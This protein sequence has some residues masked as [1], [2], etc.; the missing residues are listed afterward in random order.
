MFFALIAKLLQLLNFLTLSNDQ[1]PV[2]P[3]HRPFEQSLFLFFLAPACE[4]GFEPTF[5]T[6]AE[7]NIQ[8]LNLSRT[9]LQGSN[10]NRVKASRMTVSAD[11]LCR[12]FFWNYPFPS[13]K[14]EY[15]DNDLK[16]CAFCL[17]FKFPKFS[18]NF[19]LL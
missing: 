6:Q 2:K 5:L 3:R 1:N 19:K 18:L 13:K 10:S 8:K 17:N 4:D 11:F 15:F 12:N 14:P 9:E 16:F 7:P